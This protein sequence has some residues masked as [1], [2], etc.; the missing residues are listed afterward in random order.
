[1]RTP[2]AQPSGIP[3]RIGRYR[4]IRPLS[5]GG[6]AFVY[7]ARRESLAGVAPRVAIKLILPD[8]AGSET[9][10]E[11]F[12]NEARLGA[13]MQHQNLVQIQDFDAD[14]DRYFLVMEY[15]DGF[16]LAKVIRTIAKHNLSVPMPAIAEIGRQ[17]CDGLHYAHMASDADGRQLHL[18]H[19]DIKPSNLILSV[20]GVVKI[21]DFGI[22]KGVF[23]PEKDGSVKGTWGYMAPEQA[24]GK[25]VGPTADIFGL[26]VVL[27]ELAAGRQMFRSK[28]QVAIRQML[29]AGH[30]VEQVDTLPEDLAPLAQVLRRAVQ[31]KA[32]L[33][34]PSAAAFGQELAELIVD[35]IRVREQ[36]SGLYLQM[37][38]TVPMPSPRSSPVRRTM[39][40]VV[41]AQNPPTVDRNAVAFTLAG[42]AVALLSSA[43]LLMVILNM[44][45]WGNRTLKPAPAPPRVI[46]EAPGE[47]SPVVPAPA[48][49]PDSAPVPAP[50]SPVAPSP[51]PSPVPSTVVVP[52]VAPAPS[53]VQAPEPVDSPKPRVVVRRVEPDSTIGAEESGSMSIRCLQSAEIYIDGALVRDPSAANSYPPGQHVI[54]IVTDDGRKKSV[55]VDLQPGQ[56]ISRTWDFERMEWR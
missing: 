54:S 18:V 49:T 53:P 1:M 13:A 19:R 30:A 23:R 17:A 34:Y 48:V 26:G 12:I 7:E 31:T 56:S 21:L 25:E 9:F 43:V 45:S 35:P 42:T 5:K 33:R 20:Q 44:V 8:Y 52:A 40:S 16:T 29:R 32:E 4:I 27:W 38:G 24:M 28:D 6:M 37:T 50:S 14:G 36:V 10:K 11:L 2:A 51:G 41:D 46:E 22:S 15:V 47:A 55:M 39:P 3:E